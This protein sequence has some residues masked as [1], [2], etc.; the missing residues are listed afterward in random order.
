MGAILYLVRHGR[1]ETARQGQSDETR[2]LTVAGIAE[3]ERS[4]QGLINLDVHPV[5]IVTSPLLRALQTAQIFH[6]KLAPTSPLL[7][8]K[9][10][11]SG[12][13]LTSMFGV[14]EAAIG[15]SSP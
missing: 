6:D 4:S 14:L 13:T 12:A 10:L 3:L 7:E 11:A 15:R 8:E 5:R 9:N 2:A 1:A